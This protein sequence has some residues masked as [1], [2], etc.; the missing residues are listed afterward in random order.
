MALSKKRLNELREMK[1]SE[2]NEEIILKELESMEE[3]QKTVE[4]AVEKDKKTVF[5]LKLVMENDKKVAK[6]LKIRVQ[7]KEDKIKSNQSLLKNW[8]NPTVEELND[9]YLSFIEK[10]Y[11]KDIE[12]YIKELEEESGK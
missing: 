8:I 11:E 10:K 9:I 12:K 2:E 1:Y 4:K 6:A 5:N 7:I 3:N